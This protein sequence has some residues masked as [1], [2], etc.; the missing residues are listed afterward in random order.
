MYCF[1]HQRLNRLNPSL[2]NQ[3]GLDGTKRYQYAPDGFANS[4]KAVG[5]TDDIFSAETSI[6]ELYLLPL[7]S[8]DLSLSTTGAFDYPFGFYSFHS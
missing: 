8:N 6:G 7:E 2:L 1:Y 4:T 3:G 5:L